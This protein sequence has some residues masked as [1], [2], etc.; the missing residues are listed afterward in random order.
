MDTFHARNEI[1][2]LFHTDYI[3]GLMSG[4]TSE[5]KPI[6]PLWTLS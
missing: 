3:I 2:R 1:T 5:T 6:L 4:I